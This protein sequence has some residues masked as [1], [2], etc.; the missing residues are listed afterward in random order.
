MKIITDKLPE[1]TYGFQFR[2]ERRGDT[3]TVH[4]H[5]WSHWAGADKKAAVYVQN[6]RGEPEV[7]LPSSGSWCFV[8]ARRIHAVV[9]LEDDCA[10]E[11]HFP[12]KDESGQRIENPKEGALE[13]LYEVE[14][15]FRRQLK[16][17]LEVL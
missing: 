5:K 4:A 3:T 1:E 6:E 9:A 17:L 16:L 12:V 8:P 15:E 14:L 13:V 2:L 11:C 10:C 7:Y